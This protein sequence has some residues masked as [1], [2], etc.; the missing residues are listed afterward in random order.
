MYFWLMVL[1]LGLFGAL[2]DVSLNQWGKIPSIFRWTESAG[3]FLAFM[4]G[5]GIS[6]RLGEARGHSLTAVVLVVLLAN[7]VGVGIWDFFVAET[8]FTTSQW[9]GVILAVFAI[10]CFEAGKK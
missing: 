4:T 5:F 3:L 8:R 6:M 1:F 10:V 7:V 2:A 9:V